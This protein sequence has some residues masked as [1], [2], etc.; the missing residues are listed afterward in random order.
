MDF[1]TVHFNIT[2]TC[3]S[4]YVNTRPCYAVHF[5]VQMDSSLVKC[6]ESD[7]RYPDQVRFVIRHYG[8]RYNINGSHLKRYLGLTALLF[9]LIIN[10]FI[11]P[12]L[13]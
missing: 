6:A 13:M 8:L 1:E 2:D 4:S 9:S 12:K 11:V 5:K 7:C 3:W 10:M